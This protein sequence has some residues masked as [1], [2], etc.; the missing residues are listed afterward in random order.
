MN[1]LNNRRD[2]PRS[3]TRVAEIVFRANAGE[4]GAGYSSYGECLLR[5]LGE[6]PPPFGMAWYGKQYRSYACDPYWLA[7]SLVANSDVEAD[8][9]KKLWNLA[10]QA[11]GDLS[12]KL[13]RHSADESGHARLYINLLYRVFPS[14]LGSD[15]RETL[16]CLNLDMRCETKLE[17]QREMSEVDL[18]DNVIQI[19][20]GEIRTLIH[21]M[22]MA[23]MLIEH[24][25]SEEKN[26]VSRLLQALRRDEVRHIAYTS[27][28]IERYASLGHKEFILETMKK[29]L[30]FFN[31]MT[32]NQVSA[33][34]VDGK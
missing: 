29:R 9:A 23:P 32:L 4:G 30:A 2:I 6:Y 16:G 24:S 11:S 19:N 10:S 7:T 26:V 31:E 1:P 13:R 18:L 25:N 5:A 8:G 27:E 14:S 28:V 33:L 12:D 20:L 3:S 21:Q 34:V 15:L 17:M 22:L